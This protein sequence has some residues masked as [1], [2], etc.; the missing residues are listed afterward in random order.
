M[1]ATGKTVKTKET[2]TEKAAA[3]EESNTPAVEVE[4]VSE[5]IEKDKVPK[6]DDKCCSNVPME[7][8]LLNLLFSDAF[9]YLTLI[10]IWEKT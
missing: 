5:T 3:S 8:C 10:K 9:M 6:I 2:P 7:F 1:K 4:I